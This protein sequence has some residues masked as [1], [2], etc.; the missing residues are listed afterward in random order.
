[1]YWLFFSKNIYLRH[2][3]DSS[4]IVH[5]RITYNLV[6]RLSFIGGTFSLLKNLFGVVIMV[7]SKFTFVME[8]IM[9]LYVART[10]K[11]DIF[12]VNENMKN[13]KRF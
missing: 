4:I 6:D 3:L 8:A 7:I 1:M 13:D 11:N 12:V 10:K 2:T 5:S 9:N